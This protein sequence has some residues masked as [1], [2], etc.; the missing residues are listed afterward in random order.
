[1][2]TL[3]ATIDELK[4]AG[5]AYSVEQGSKHFKIKA[6]GLPLIVCSVSCSDHRGELKARSLVRRLIRKNGLGA[7][8]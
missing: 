2:S 7:V 6:D 1:M 5:L 8:A 4:Q 3:K